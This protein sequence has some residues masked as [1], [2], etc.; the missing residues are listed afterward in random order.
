MNFNSNTAVKYKKIVEFGCKNTDKEFD[1]LHDAKT[2]CT[3]DIECNWILDRNG[4]HDT[5]KICAVGDIL[6]NDVIPELAYEFGIAESSVYAK[7]EK[8]GEYCRLS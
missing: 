7:L 2:Y 1:N 6:S 4:K 3:S 5:F 8:R